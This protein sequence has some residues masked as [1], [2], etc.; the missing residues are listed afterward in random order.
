MYLEV[1]FGINYEVADSISVYAGGYAGY[2]LSQSSS[3]ELAGVT[4]ED[5]NAT[6]TI[7]KGDYGVQLGAAW[8]MDEWTASVGYQLGLA[9][10][11]VAEGSD[12]VSS[13]Q[14]QVGYN[15]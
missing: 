9:D 5:P 8:S 4:A 10:V 15:F 6:D 13:I 3:L 1:P 11:T 2:A 12:K 14:A 7:R